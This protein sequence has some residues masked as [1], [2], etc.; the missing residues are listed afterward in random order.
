MVVEAAAA[1]QALRG[2]PAR[3]SLTP[4]VAPAAA[5]G[6]GVP[7]VAQG[8]RTHAL[9]AGADTEKTVLLG[10]VPTC[11]GARGGVG[12]GRAGGPLSCPWRFL[13]QESGE[14]LHGKPRALPSQGLPKG[15]G[16]LKGTW[17]PWAGL[18]VPAEAH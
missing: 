7:K 15:W 3:A 12:P 2:A 1:G 10:P 5:A 11:T 14:G 9:P 13:M 18:P 4:L 16:H 8:A 6:C 17:L